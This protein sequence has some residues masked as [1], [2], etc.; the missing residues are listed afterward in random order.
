MRGE[1]EPELRARVLE[2]RASRP[3]PFRDDKAIASWNGLAL[4]ALA[5]AA[6]RLERDDWLRAA[7]ELGEF[8]LGPLSAADGSLYRS[9]RDG[10]PSGLGFLDDYA[11]A[12][13][14]L[15][16]LHVATGELRWLLEARR[17]ALL[18]VEL[19][20]DEEHGGFFLSTADG[21]ARVPRTKEFQD[22]PLPSGNSMLA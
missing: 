18:A 3:Q 19:F 16:E 5:E 12:A 15:M 8:L 13:N 1:L 11:N 21:D 6:Y 4:A 22:T 9:L 7:S 10:V 2:L 14:G 17:L 20:G